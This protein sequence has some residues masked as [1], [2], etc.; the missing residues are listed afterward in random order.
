V[1]DFGFP[2]FDTCVLCL[3]FSF[4]DR[5]GPPR[6]FPSHFWKLFLMTGCFLFLIFS[7]SVL[8]CL[9]RTSVSAV[10]IL[11]Q[12]H[13]LHYCQRTDLYFSNFLA[14][15][16]PNSPLTW[17]NLPQSFPFPP[18]PCKPFPHGPLGPLYARCHPMT[19]YF[20]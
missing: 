10:L 9:V 1:A 5:L 13:P 2:R 8:S 6:L 18:P 11:D 15:F 16:C 4:L 14:S 17:P 3:P 19:G 12:F 20:T 7:C